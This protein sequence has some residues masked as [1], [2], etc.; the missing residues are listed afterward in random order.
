MANLISYGATNTLLVGITPVM[1]QFIQ[2]ARSMGWKLYATDTSRGRCAYRERT[3]TVPLF[4]LNRGLE[5]KLW[6]ISHEVAH[7]FAGSSAK[8]GPEFMRNLKLICPESSLVHE[9][10]YKPLNAVKAGIVCGDF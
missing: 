6:Y 2:D 1:A 4:A 3:V 9:I 10:G 8:H 5:Y 7:I